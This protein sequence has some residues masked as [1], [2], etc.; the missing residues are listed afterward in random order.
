[1]TRIKLSLIVVAAA[2]AVVAATAVANDQ[3][4]HNVQYPPNTGVKLDFAS[5]TAAPAANLEAKINLKDDQA[6]IELSWADLKPALLFGGDV[7]CYVLWAVT[8]GG[9]AKN[10]GEVPSG[11]PKGNAQYGTGLKGFALMVTA[12]AYTQGWQP[13]ELVM[14]VND[15]P[16]KKK[17]GVQTFQYSAFGTAPDHDLASIRAVAWDDPN[18][19]ELVQAERAFAFA[20]RINAEQYAPSLVQDAR[21]LL[22]QASNLVTSSR[23]RSDGIDFAGRSFGVISNAVGEAEREIEQERLDAI[24]A[25]RTAEVDA[26]VARASEAEAS[27]QEA[28]TSLQEA[29]AERQKMESA[30]S[31]L[32]TE[33]VALTS[34][35]GSLRAEK[36]ELSGRLGA[37]L[38]Q[39]ADTQ[40]TARGMIVNLPDILFDVNESTLK[41][42]AKLVIA[43]LAGILLI[44]QDLNLRIEGHTDSTGSYDYNMR[45]SDARAR[46]VFDFL[47]T[48][49]IAGQRMTVKGYGPD[50]P[51][52]DNTTTE[53]RSRNRRV[54]IVIAEGT[55]AE[56]P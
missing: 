32:R 6:R 10:L 45:L 39:V 19:V 15:P 23:R 35:L 46:S 2:F 42:D 24:L 26:M 36:E 4:L 8:P 5:T 56:A 22:A 52:A 55:I 1:M 14:F 11:S 40:S 27:L 28:Q 50:R 20:E 53:G 7:S 29:Q 41:A 30:M 12:E 9:F 38:S 54:E 16:D 51:I 31:A 17:I 49:G 47:A 34:A 44:M 21:L 3:T 25:S 18:P 48:Q 37:A 33:Q 43:K 13:S